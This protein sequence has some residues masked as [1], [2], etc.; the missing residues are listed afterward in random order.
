M[1]RRAF[2]LIELLVVIAII[3]LLIGILLPAL[4]QARQSAKKLVGAANHRTM[5]STLGQYASQF[6]DWTPTGHT[7]TLRGG[8][9]WAY[10][11]PVQMRTAVGDDSGFEEAV[12]NPG[13]P[14]DFDTVWRSI[15]NADGQFAAGDPNRDI[16]A[17]DDTV[18]GVEYGYKPFELMVMSN[19][20]VRPLDPET[21][22]MQPLSIGWNENGT[23]GTGGDRN[24]AYFQKNGVGHNLGLGEH[25]SNRYDVQ[26]AATPAGRLEL[27]AENGPKFSAI[28]DPAGMIAIADS[29]VDLRDDPW[30]SALAAQ[31]REPG[32]YFNGQANFGFV[33]GHAEALKVE[34][35]VITPDSD[36]T[37]PAFLGRIR[38][39]NYTGSPEVQSWM[40]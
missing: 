29:L 3:A 32:A 36:A 31:E 12:L 14:R 13:A 39:W 27:R 15:I 19:T 33:D 34:D 16:G 6:D 4:G 40:P 23:A 21:Q 11:W 9:R 37:D 22:G 17:T 30:I 26:V 38:K 25:S 10:S 1:S 35:Y 7:R 2:T 20:G 5:V 28:A 24:G 18:A 8:G